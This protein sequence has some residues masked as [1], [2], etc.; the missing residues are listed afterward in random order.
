MLQPS[1][2]DDASATVPGLRSH[3]SREAAA[4]LFAAV[5]DLEE[6]RQAGA[7]L[8]EITL[9]RLVHRGDGLRGQRAER[10]RIQVRDPLEHRESGAAPRRT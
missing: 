8:G 7:A 5:E 1:V 6:V 9:G 3:E 4:E 10:A 2:V